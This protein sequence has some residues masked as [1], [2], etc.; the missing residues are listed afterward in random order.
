MSDN[1]SA[2]RLP[3]AGVPAEFVLDAGHTVLSCTPS[4]Q[5]LLGS[6]PERL[7]G[8]DF[9]SYFEDP[10]QWALLV[11][12][13]LGG[14]RQAGQAVLLGADGGK[15]AVFLDVATLVTGSGNGARLLVRLTPADGAPGAVP[16]DAGPGV[17][18]A[19]SR[20]SSR[21]DLLNATA[22]RIGTTLDIA[23]NAEEL[24]EVLVPAFA[25]LGAVD[26]TEAVLGE[27]PGEFSGEVAMRRTAVAAAAGRWPSESHPLGATLYVKDVAGE[28]LRHDSVGFVPDLADVRKLTTEDG[29]APRPELPQGATSL[30]VIPLRARGLVL[31]S[32]ALWRTGDRRPF[33]RS[34]AVL[35]EEV[36]ARAA[37]GIDNARRY[38]NER[39]T[40]EALRRSLLPRPVAD[41]AAAETAGIHV[42]A[43][44]PAGIGGSWYDVI[45]LSSTR[46]GFVVGSVPGQGLRAA[47]AMG[48]L[49]SAVETLADLDPAP[50]ELLS[51]LDDLVVRFGGTEQRENIRP[52]AAGALCGASCVYAIY[53]PVTH[54]CL[55][56][57]AGHPAPILVRQGDAGAEEV[58]IARGPTLGTGGEPFEPTELQLKPGDVLAF[59]SSALAWDSPEAKDRLATVREAAEAAARSGQPMA[60]AGRRV[61][62]RLHATSPEDD[63][64]LLLT[65]VRELPRA[66]TAAW[67]LD[68]EPREVARARAVIGAQ[69]VEWGLDDLVFATELIVSELVTNAVRYACAPITLRL[70]KEQ[71]LICEVADPSQTQPHLRRARVTD[72]GGR[73]LFLIAQL[74]H[75]WGSRYTTSGKA[76]WTEQLLDEG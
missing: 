17:L 43:D 51:H 47:A 52:G 30:L 49:R 64:A 29:G 34:D 75:R 24:V 6:S 65:R 36:G 16:P 61:Q 37:L 2:R 20:A 13:A 67:E 15:R 71:R 48:R 9:T 74:T 22:S 59:H 68:A 7:C 8:H 18:P 72:E 76:I 11:P 26:L 5:D 27:E 62:E 50:D 58:R 42:P 10:A 14:V 39:R 1:R 60:E 4:A 54:R 33:D 32:V 63:V 23:G 45:E 44:T 12:R 35:A 73:G 69:L 3:A 53:D 38:T 41:S 57:S 25:D 19:D 40:A 31:G 70:I 21:T 66:C 56:A 28:H 46:V 55:V